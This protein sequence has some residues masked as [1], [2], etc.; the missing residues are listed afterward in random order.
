MTEQK[1]YAILITN[2]LNSGYTTLHNKVFT[3]EKAAK[4]EIK[5]L[6]NEYIESKVGKKKKTKL[7]YN[8]NSLMIYSKPTLNCMFAEISYYVQEIIVQPSFGKKAEDAKMPSN[9]LTCFA[10]SE[11]DLIIK[12]AKK[13]GASK[14]EIFMQETVNHD[15]LDLVDLFATQ[16]QSGSSAPYVLNRFKR[17][18]SW[19]PLSPL[20]GE[21]D[22]WMDLD[23]CGEKTLQQ[24]K[25]YSGLFRTKGDNSTAHDVNALVFSDNG[26]VTWFSSN[27]SKD[28]LK[29]IV[30]PYTPPSTPHE[31]YIK[32]IDDNCEKY[33]LVES[34]EERKK[35]REQFRQ[36]MRE[37]GWYDE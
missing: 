34:E 12:N 18:A 11:L 25:R 28:F 22:E 16:A 17:L 24:N 27:I 4:F 3:S 15:I 13:K 1:L 14:E 36:D 7:E 37:H 32:W 10:K 20:T 19:L 29:P 23:S 26:G 9:G 33:E 6:A 35:Q 5:D 8:E 2:H 30:F 31:I 21:D